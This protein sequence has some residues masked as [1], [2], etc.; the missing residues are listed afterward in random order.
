MAPEL[1]QPKALSFQTD[2]NRTPGPACGIYR[3]MSHQ[4]YC[5]VAGH[6]WVC[7]SLDCVCICSLQ[8][9]SGDHSACPIELA[10]C[11]EHRE[12]LA[13]TSQGGRRHL[14]DPASLGDMVIA[15]ANSSESNI[16]WCL[17]CNSS[18]RNE[19][20]MI[21]GT[22]LHS[23]EAGRAARALAQWHVASSPPHTVPHERTK[24]ENHNLLR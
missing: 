20:D 1:S 18:I 24:I 8:M 9:E 11:P 2:C 12:R 13:A 19:D 3:R 10:A 7:D 6:D 14:E 23:C 22:N 4:H 17:V 5:D 21:P 15:W 16:G